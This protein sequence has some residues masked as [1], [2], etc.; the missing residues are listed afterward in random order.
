MKPPQWRPCGE[1]ELPPPTQQEPPTSDVSRPR[2]GTWTPSST[3]QESDRTSP[4]ALPEA[5][6]GKSVKTGGLNGI[7]SLHCIHSTQMSRFQLKI[8]HNTG[9]TLG[10]GKIEGRR[11]RGP[12]LCPGRL[13]TLK[14]Y[15]KVQLAHQISTKI[16]WMDG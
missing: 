6:Q 1:L 14:L 11:G 13:C 7:R 15:H 4:P 12:C 5:C 2:Q 10:P 3:M 8:S 16:R 9:K